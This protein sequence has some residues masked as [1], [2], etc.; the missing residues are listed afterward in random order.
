M[1]TFIQ[2]F[3]GG[4]LYPALV[5]AAMLSLVASVSYRIVIARRGEL[6]SAA[7][8]AG[9]WFAYRL[10]Q[11]FYSSRY[12]EARSSSARG[13]RGC[14]AAHDR[15]ESAR[16]ACRYDRMR[17][18]HAAREPVRRRSLIHWHLHVAGALGCGI[19]TSHAV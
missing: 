16:A 19:P 11:S 6:Y 8:G 13:T 14:R 9:L 5:L 10:A 3:F 4:V 1:D 7:L 18:S 12:R 17:R 2:G 15:I